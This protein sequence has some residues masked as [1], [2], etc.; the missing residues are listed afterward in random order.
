MREVAKVVGLLVASFAWVLYGPLF[1]HQIEI[2]KAAAL[3][4]KEVILMPP[5]SSLLLLVLTSTG[6]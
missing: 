3:K 6:G 1:Y 5:C 4:N 2:G